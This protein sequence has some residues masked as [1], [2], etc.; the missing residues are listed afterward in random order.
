[1]KLFQ[2]V[3]GFTIVGLHGI[4]FTKTLTST[5]MIFLFASANIL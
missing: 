3:A 1:M 4:Y 5:F 2:S